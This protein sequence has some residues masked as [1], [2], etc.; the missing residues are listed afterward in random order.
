VPSC[1]TLEDLHYAIQDV[2]GWLNCHLHVFIAGGDLYGVIRKSNDPLAE[3][4][5]TKDERSITLAQVV[6][7]GVIRFRYE[8]DFGDCWMHEIMVEDKDAPVPADGLP[9]CVDGARRCPPE[10]VGGPDGYE[11]LLD[12]LGDPEDAEHEELKEWVGPRFNPEHF[13]KRLATALLR[14]QFTRTLT[15]RAMRRQHTSA[16]KKKAARK[17]RAV[18]M[19]PP[20]V[21]G[22][23]GPRKGA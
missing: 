2:F 16:K 7:A 23:V 9:L 8:Y 5:R 22:V 20:H 19:P 15:E 1:C 10:D 12:I 13:D 4:D 14:K 3:E 6:G 17:P 21:A 11:R 18:W